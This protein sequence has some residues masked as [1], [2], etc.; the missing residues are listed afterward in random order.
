MTV[1]HRSRIRRDPNAPNLRQ[2][3][4]LQ[5]ELF[6]ELAQMGFRVEPGELGENITTQDTDILAMPTGT[7][8]HI[9]RSIIELTGLRNP[10]LQLDRF[11]QGL[12]AATLDRALDNSLVRKAG[13]MGIVLAGGRI[14]PGD[15]ITAILPTGEARPLLPV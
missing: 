7:R 10:C 3:H 13:V 9:G 6:D 12:M 4:L 11:S 5:R 15:P 1:K 8:L 2:V 14:Q